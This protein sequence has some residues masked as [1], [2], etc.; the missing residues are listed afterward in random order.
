VAFTEAPATTAPEL[1][2]TV[3]KINAL[4]VCDHAQITLQYEIANNRR[5][6]DS[7]HPLVDSHPTAPYSTHF[8]P[9][10]I[11]PLP[12]RTTSAIDVSAL[13][14]QSFFSLEQSYIPREALSNSWSSLFV[15]ARRAGTLK[16]VYANAPRTREAAMPFAF[17]SESPFIFAGLNRPGHSR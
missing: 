1:S 15:N 12:D 9:L 7:T 10:G 6:M 5:Y 3:P 13:P 17:P 8:C 14:F 2:L 4:V 16:P 11:T